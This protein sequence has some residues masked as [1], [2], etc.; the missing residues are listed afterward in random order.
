MPPASGRQAQHRRRAH[1]GP[2]REHH[3]RGMHERQ[4]RLAHE[5]APPQLLERCPVQAGSSRQGAAALTMNMLACEAKEHAER[6]G[7]VVLASA[8][9]SFDV[10]LPSVWGARGV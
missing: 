9:P 7:H 8:S 1:K 10:A 5:A 4:A 3:R 6:T 2:E